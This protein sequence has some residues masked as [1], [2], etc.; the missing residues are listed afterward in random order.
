MNHNRTMSEREKSLRRLQASSFAVNETVLYL[1]THPESKSAKAYL[2]RRLADRAMA[3]TDFQSAYG[4]VLVDNLDGDDAY[5]W[6]DCPM[7]W[8]E[9]GN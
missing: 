7:P 6:V 5:T 1:D 4:A 3:L 8:E 2:D 9:G